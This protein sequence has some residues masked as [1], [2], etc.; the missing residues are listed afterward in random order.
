[1]PKIYDTLTKLEG[2]GVHLVQYGYAEAPEVALL[3]YD[4]KDLNDQNLDFRSMKLKNVSQLAS[5]TATGESIEW[6][7]EDLKAA[8][9]NINTFTSATSIVVDA[10][11]VSV[12]EMLYNQT[13]GGVEA[14]VVNVVG[15][16][17]T[18][19]A[20]GLA[21]GAVN[22]KLVRSSF[23]KKYGVDHA[24]RS[25]KND[26]ISLT[27]YIQFTEHAIDS[28][29]ILNN[30]TLLY[31][32]QEDKD[33]RRFGDASRN[34]IRGIASGFY[35]G[36]KLKSNASGTDQYSAGGLEEFILA[37]NKVN[38]KGADNAATKANLRNQ[39]QKA[40]QCGLSGVRQKNKILFFCNTAFA[41]MIHDLYEAAIQYNDELTGINLNIKTYS[42]AGYNMSLVVS[43]HL[44]Y[45]I[46]ST[47]P[48][49][50]V[51]PIDY[52]FLYML[53]RGALKEDGK[54]AQLV[55]RGV[56]YKKPQSTFEKS[57]IALAT[58]YSF[59]FQGVNSGGFRKL[60]YV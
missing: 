5:I 40:Y 60:T 46:G 54:T 56:V 11:D 3:M 26:L 15:S 28:D 31:I 32:S 2:K 25:N 18:L 52:A 24:L 13:T 59:M 8:L 58:N 29:M 10:T 45:H 16:T 35:T 19:A 51:V 41:N 34:I 27:N 50:Y 48:T 23:A 39:I 9:L 17:L 14:M 57:T 33:K 55:G 7:E 49:C 30:Q 47:I 1:M 38:I 37:G 42:V 36:K 6:N 20:P 44:D 53:P 12:G 43:N 21:G 22:N 4:M